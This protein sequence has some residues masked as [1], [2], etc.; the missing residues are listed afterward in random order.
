MVE[1]VRAKQRLGKETTAPRLIQADELQRTGES[2]D[3]VMPPPVGVPQAGGG[4]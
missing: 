2:I 3:L 4:S 1:D